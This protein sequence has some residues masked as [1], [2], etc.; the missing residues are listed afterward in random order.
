[1]LSTDNVFSIRNVILPYYV[2]EEEQIFVRRPSNDS[3]GL[4]LA[5]MKAGNERNDA[6]RHNLC[7]V[8]ELLNTQMLVRSK[9]PFLTLSYL[10]HLILFV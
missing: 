10:Q 3:C 9:K 7:L 2:E 8:T 1:M 6:I 4:F 5:G